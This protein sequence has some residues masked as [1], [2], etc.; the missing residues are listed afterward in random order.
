MFFWKIYVIFALN[1]LADKYKTNYL[2]QC[3]AQNLKRNVQD[4]N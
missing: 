2:K 1:P 3:I 4:V